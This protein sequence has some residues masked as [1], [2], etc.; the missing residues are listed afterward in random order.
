MLAA[1]LDRVPPFGWGRSD[2]LLWLADW[3][4]L[5]GHEDAAAGWRGAYDTPRRAA[6]ALAQAGGMDSVMAGAAARLGLVAVDVDAPLAGDVG[7]AA[8]GRGPLHRTG[9]IFDGTLWRVRAP[10]HT[11]IGLAARPVAVYRSA[12]CHN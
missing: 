7:L 5:L 9:V 2:C 6:R 8:F 4:M 10:N 12:I 11:I 3:L 1:F